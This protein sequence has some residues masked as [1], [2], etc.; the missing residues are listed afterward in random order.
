MNTETVVT[1]GTETTTKKTRSKSVFAGAREFIV[2]YLS[3]QRAGK[4]LNEFASDSGM[5]PLSLRS[6]IALMKKKGVLLPDLK[7]QTTSKRGRQQ[8]DVD[9]LNALISSGN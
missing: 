8:L 1:T 7:K 9:E 6:R 4:T 3:A 5:R 2:A